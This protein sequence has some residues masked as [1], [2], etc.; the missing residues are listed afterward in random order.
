MLNLY[1]VRHSI[2]QW[3]EEKKV[4]GHTDVPLNENGRELAKKTGLHMAGEGISF[5]EAYCSPLA[6]AKE[7]AQI[8]LQS[9]GRPPALVEDDRLKELCFGEFEGLSCFG[10][11]PD[12]KC[13]RFRLFYKD[14]LHYVPGEGG[15]TISQLY[16]RLRSFISS[17]YASDVS[18]NKKNILIVTHGA[19]LNGMLN[20][21]EDKPVI[22]G[23][24]DRKVSINCGVS[25]VKIEGGRAEIEYENRGIEEK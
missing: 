7:T 24:W 20:L 6:R 3:N 4:Q 10:G 25:L 23:F 15:E 14:T 5:D 1:I 9:V 21:L 12:P 13:V 11:N 17:L 22:D 16:D 18:G 2:T 8:I 19:A